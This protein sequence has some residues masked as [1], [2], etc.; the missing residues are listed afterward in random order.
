MANRTHTR[1]GFLKTVPAAAGCLA[2]S[3]GWS[4]GE[5]EPVIARIE[6][7]PQTHPLV[8]ALRMAHDCHQAVADVDNYTAEFVKKELIGRQLIESR[9]CHVEIGHQS[10]P[11]QSQG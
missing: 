3:A 6:A 5:D 4:F 7:A 9:L 8:P 1:R 2:L 11:E 10:L